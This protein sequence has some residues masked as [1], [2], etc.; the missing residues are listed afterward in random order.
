[1]VDP[2]NHTLALLREMRAEMQARFDEIERRFDRIEKRLGGMH[3]NGIEALK[4]L[5]GHRSMV[6]RSMASCEVDGSE[7][8]RRVSALEAAQV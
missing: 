1:M 8:K 4:G 7:P 6:G 3:E 2:D 5:I